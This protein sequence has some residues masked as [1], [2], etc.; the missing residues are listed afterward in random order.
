MPELILHFEA[1]GDTDLSAAAA[2]L[3]AELTRAASLE[4]AKTR[5]QKYQSVGPAEIL[6]V[7]QVATSVAQSTAGLLTALATVYAAWENFGPLFP[8]LRHPQWKWA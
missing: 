4:S 2:A 1:S 5:P 3:E 8:G 6:S 7:I